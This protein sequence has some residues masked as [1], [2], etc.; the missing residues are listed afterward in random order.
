MTPPDEPDIGDEVCQVTG[1]TEFEVLDTELCPEHLQERAEDEQ[2]ERQ[3]DRM[4]D[5]GYQ[6]P[7]GFD[8]R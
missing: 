1:C 8:G 6:Y 3:I 5:N 2:A 4:N 7:K